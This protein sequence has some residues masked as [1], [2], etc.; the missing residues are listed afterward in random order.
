MRGQVNTTA[1]ITIAVT[2]AI[3]AMASVVAS[4]RITEGKIDVVNA[5]ASE[6]LQR[7]SVEETKSDQYEKDINSMN[8][9]LDDIL[10]ELRN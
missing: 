4:V 5:N 3:A 2:I 6:A 7:I 10:K 9:K 1:V 8:V